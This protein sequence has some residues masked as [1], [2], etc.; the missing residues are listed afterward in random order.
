MNLI[1]ITVRDSTVVMKVGH[2]FIDYLLHHVVTSINWCAYDSDQRSLFRITVCFF[3]TSVPISPCLNDCPITLS[4][5]QLRY[6]LHLCILFLN[7]CSSVILRP[8][9]LI[10]RNH[11]PSKF[12]SNTQVT[13]ERKYWGHIKFPGC[14]LDIEDVSSA[15]L[16]KSSC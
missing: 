11:Q 9:V 1:W 12:S 10:P 13:Q 8:C 15:N 5:M 4:C 7:M 3:W 2:R 16:R 6:S 14:V